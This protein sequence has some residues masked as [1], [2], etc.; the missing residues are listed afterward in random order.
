[1]DEIPHVPTVFFCLFSRYFVPI[2]WA[3]V[4]IHT[5]SLPSILCNTFTHCCGVLCHNRLKCFDIFFVAHIRDGHHCCCLQR[6]ATAAAAAA[7]AAAFA[8]VLQLHCCCCVALLVLQS[9]RCC[10]YVQQNCFVISTELFFVFFSLFVDSV[11]YY[12]TAL[13]LWA[14]HVS[15]LSDFRTH[16]MP[17]SP[18]SPP[19]IPIKPNHLQGDDFFSGL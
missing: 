16:T 7:A 11:D 19:P 3:A 4:W 13:D 12:C 14:K 17:L 10:C 2:I 6:R 5:S 9:K 8:A 15:I 18:Y 1:M